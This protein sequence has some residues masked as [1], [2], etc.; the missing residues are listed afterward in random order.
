VTTASWAKVRRAR[1][2]IDTESRRFRH[3]IK[4]AGNHD[5][6]HVCEWFTLFRWL[7]R[8]VGKKYLYGKIVSRYR[9]QCFQYFR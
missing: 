4:K 1:G 8:S 5:P 9:V 3:C 7:G 6:T 2:S